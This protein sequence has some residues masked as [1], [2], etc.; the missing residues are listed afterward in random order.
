MPAKRVLLVIT[1]FFCVKAVV[2]PSLQKEEKKFKK[3]A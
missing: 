3:S 2:S 1:G